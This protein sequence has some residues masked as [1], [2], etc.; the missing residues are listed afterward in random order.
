MFFLSFLVQHDI[1]DKYDN[2]FGMI[3]E[4]V[5]IA[6]TYEELQNLNNQAIDRIGIK[7]ARFSLGKIPN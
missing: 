5:T 1:V 3:N 7:N 2:A 4:D 6:G